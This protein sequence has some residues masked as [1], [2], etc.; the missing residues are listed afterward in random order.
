MKHRTELE[1]GCFVADRSDLELTTDGCMHWCQ[2]I[3][4]GD[5]ARRISLFYAEVGEGNAPPLNTGAGEAVLFLL[6]GECHVGIGDRQFLAGRNCGV[7]VRR[8]ETFRF[9]NSS[10]S[11]ACWLI[12][13]CPRIEGLHWADNMSDAFDDRFQ[14]RAVFAGDRAKQATGDRYYKLLV[15][16]QSGSREVTQFIGMIPRSK[17]PEHF[18]LYEEAIC[19][20]SGTGLM[21][22]GKKSA[23]VG[24]G[25]MIFLPRKQPHCLE[26][27]CD[28]GLELMGMF[29]PAGSPA[30]NYE[31]GL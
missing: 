11:P 19:I 16:P 21:W 31:T 5:A 22:T 18:H 2:V 23:E 30:V 17:A 28:E 7:H 25:N 4:A 9:V 10:S 26:C 13:M 1:S 3:G 29:Y 24:P 20:I 12:G 27:T 15:G 14:N 6:E 8:G